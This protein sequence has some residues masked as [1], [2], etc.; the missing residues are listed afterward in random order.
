MNGKEVSGKVLAT[1]NSFI[2]IKLESKFTIVFLSV[3]VKLNP[4]STR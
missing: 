4:L 2:Q 3:V 1:F